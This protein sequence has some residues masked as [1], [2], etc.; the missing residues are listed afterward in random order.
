MKV[1]ITGHQD[2]GDQNHISKIKKELTKILLNESVTLGLTSLAKG[3]GQLFAEVLSEN[4]I[5]YCVVIPSKGYSETFEDKVSLK[6]YHYFLNESDQRVTLSFDY[7]KEKASYDAGKYIVENSDCI[8]AI[9]NGKLAE[10]LGG[11][12][13]IVDY[14]LKKNKRVIHLNSIDL[15]VKIL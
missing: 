6:K 10:G 12:A 11:T 13:D 7:P 8:I 9:W 14:S 2:I 1:G 5:S 15:K 4:A 3:A